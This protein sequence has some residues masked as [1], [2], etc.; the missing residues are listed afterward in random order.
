[1]LKYESQYFLFLVA[2]C[3]EAFSSGPSQTA[4]L[5][6]CA[7]PLNNISNTENK[8]RD[9]KTEVAVILAQIA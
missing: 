8:V 5:T 6:G 1:M 2:V 9:N 3:L 7:V 4:C